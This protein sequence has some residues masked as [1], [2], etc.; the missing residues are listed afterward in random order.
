MRVRALLSVFVRAHTR[1]CIY[2]EC[3]VHV[4]MYVYTHKAIGSKTTATAQ[5]GDETFTATGKHMKEKKRSDLHVIR[6]Q[7]R[8]REGR[9]KNVLHTKKRQIINKNVRTLNLPYR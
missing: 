6:E 8:G 2:H 4:I 7:D 1:A 9:K 3:N 5:Y